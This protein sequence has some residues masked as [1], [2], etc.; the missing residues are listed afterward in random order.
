[1]EYTTEGLNKLSKELFDAVVQMGFNNDIPTRVALIHSEVSEMFEAYRQGKELKMVDGDKTQLSEIADD[2]T[3]K[4]FFE[5]HVKGTVEDEIA[6]SL[7]RLL[8]LIG[9]LDIDIEYHV[10]QKMRYNAL[11]GHK[12]GKK[13]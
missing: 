1:M 9:Y 8:D 12:F 11:R 5:N 6:D 3:F 2:E 13:F 10:Q 7:I 4:K